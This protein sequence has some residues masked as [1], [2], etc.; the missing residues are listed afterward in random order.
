M[1]ITFID[2]Y[3]IH[4]LE[5]NFVNRDGKLLYGE[6]WVYQQLILLQ[7]KIEETWLVKHSPMKENL[8]TY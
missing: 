1:P 5:E 3:P 7:D 2:N 6:L 8:S 4:S